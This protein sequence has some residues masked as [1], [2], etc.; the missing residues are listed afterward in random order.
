MPTRSSTTRF[1][2][3]AWLISAVLFVAL[4]LGAE[5]RRVVIMH[6]NDIHGHLL[7]DVGAG[8][9]AMIATIVKNVRPDLLF[10]GGD[11]FSGT[12]VSDTFAGVPVLEVMNHL[13]YSAAT[14]GNHE[15]DYGLDALSARARE[16]E[17]PFLSANVV[18]PIP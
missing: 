8:G 9:L 6:T 3:A 13:G 16:A 1:V 17:F 11:M 5:Q 7:P 18:M 14:I 2:A 15:F 4:A 10:D 12:L